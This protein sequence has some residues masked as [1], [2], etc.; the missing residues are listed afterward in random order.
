MIL[1]ELSTFWEFPRTF[2]IHFRG[3][4]STLPKKHVINISGDKKTVSSSLL[5]NNKNSDMAV[6]E[7]WAHK[8]QHQIQEP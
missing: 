1:D 6:W 7:Q 5:N 2:P 8:S 3:C 4:D